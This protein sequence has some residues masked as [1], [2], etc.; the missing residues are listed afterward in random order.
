V[1][2]VRELT[3]KWG[4]AAADDVAASAGVMLD[5]GPT[6]AFPRPSDQDDLILGH[7]GRLL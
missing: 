5:Q 7:F 2:V 6:D 1:P 3:F 4:P